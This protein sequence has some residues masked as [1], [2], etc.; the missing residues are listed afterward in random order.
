MEPAGNGGGKSGGKG[1]NKSN[2]IK[3]EAERFCMV[4]A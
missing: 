2:P 4:R 3:Q 1:D